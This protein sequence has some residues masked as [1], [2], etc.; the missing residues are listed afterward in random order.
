ME[1]E[2]PVGYRNFGAQ[3][4]GIIVPAI[5]DCFIEDAPSLEAGITEAKATI[6]A[7][8]SRLSASGSL[9]ELDIQPIDELADKSD[10]FEFM[11]M[12]IKITDADLAQIT[13]PYRVDL[14]SNLIGQ[15]Q[16][17]ARKLNIPESK[18][19]EKVLQDFFRVDLVKSLAT[20]PARAPQPLKVN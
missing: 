20:R 13:Q 19:I 18:L 10:Y 14:P 12:T 17:S 7:F 16:D 1:F 6:L 5:E 9:P 15:I 4:Y 11:W 3:S 8:L 2:F